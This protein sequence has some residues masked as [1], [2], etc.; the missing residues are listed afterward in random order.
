MANEAAGP[1]RL[2]AS[3]TYDDVIDPRELRN[4]LG[5]P[6]PGGE[7]TRPEPV[8]HTGLP[9]VSTVLVEVADGVATLTLRPGEAQRL[10]GAGRAGAR[11]GVRALRRRR[12]RPRGRAHRHPPAFCSGADLSAGSPPS[13]GPTPAS[14]PRACAS[15]P[16]SGLQ[17]V[18]AAVNGHALG[19]G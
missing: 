1:W 7:T 5:R 15:M 3:A 11:G 10:S 9:P 12:R 17:L 18:I 6:A 8:V 19:S 16:S 13:P 4:A 14:A 2:A